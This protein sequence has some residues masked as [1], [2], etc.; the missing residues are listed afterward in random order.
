MR[1]AILTLVLAAFSARAELP[2]YDLQARV[3]RND[4]TVAANVTITLPPAAETNFLLGGTFRI[5]QASASG[6]SVTVAPTDKPWKGLQRI[7]VRSRRPLRR[8]KLQIRYAGPLGSTGTPPLNTISKDLVE[9]NLDGMWVPVVEGFTTRFTLDA[10]IDGIPRELIALAPGRVT[11]SGRR[12]VI[13][14]DDDI[15]V[16]FVASRGL[17]QMSADGFELYSLDPQSELSQLY[18]QHG[19]GALTFLESWF[20]R[21]PGRPV[22]VVVVR[23]PRESGYARRGYVVVSEARRSGGDAPMAKFIAHE[24][25]HAWWAPVDPNTEH[26]WL[27]ES[28]AEYVA[29]RYIDSALGKAALEQLLTLKREIA[30]NATS[31]LGRGARTDAELYNKGPLLLFDLEEK[32]GREK[33]D[34]VLRELAQNPPSETSQFLDV[35]RQVAGEDAARMFEATLRAE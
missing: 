8:V 31:I 2:H 10:T 25:A 7:T 1:L 34:Q 33:L 14:R 22:R 24:F 12:I 11:R 21:M 20:G 19:T 23:R 35:L 16:A 30:K 15:D 13:D 27:Q 9:L 5:T 17:H 18:V 6:A 4:G 3:M 26:R 29:L 28:I 32:I